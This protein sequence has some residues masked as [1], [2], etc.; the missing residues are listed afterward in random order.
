MALDINDYDFETK[1]QKAK[2]IEDNAKFVCPNCGDTY[3]SLAEALTCCHSDCYEQ[4]KTFIE[5][6]LAD[7]RMR[8]EKGD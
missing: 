3:K 8:Q 4:D 2:F 6:E 7:F 1:D 5:E